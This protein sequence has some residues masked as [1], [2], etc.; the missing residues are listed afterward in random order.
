MYIY[1]YCRWQNVVRTGSFLIAMPNSS[2]VPLKPM[3]AFEMLF[4]FLKLVQTF[5]KRL[6]ELPSF[7]PNVLVHLEKRLESAVALQRNVVANAR[8]INVILHQLETVKP[9]IKKSSG[10]MCA[11][12]ELTLR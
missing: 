12:T 8:A 5:Q 4:S 1:I 3:T 7:R 11:M 6:A 10:Y 2:R 9:L